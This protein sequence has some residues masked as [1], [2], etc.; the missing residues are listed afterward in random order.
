MALTNR[1]VQ[2]A[3]Y[4]LPDASGTITSFDSAQVLWTYT[5]MLRIALGGGLT[6]DGTLSRVVTYARGLGGTLAPAGTLTK[7]T[8]LALGGG[9]APGGA[10]APAPTYVVALGG[11]L[12]P[13][14]ALSA[15]NP[16]WLL[17]PDNLTWQGVWDVT[18]TYGDRDVVIHASGD[19]LHAF[20]S[21][22]AHN[23]GNN[24]VTAH[25]WWTRLVQ[26]EWSG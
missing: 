21:K 23:T 2:T 7:G 14:G 9:L 3:L 15:G 13:A 24:P 12:T 20:V 17:I 8:W 11:V 22:A 1:Q 6:P 25:A 4:R 5:D 18:A 10:L 16:T 19:L 26:E